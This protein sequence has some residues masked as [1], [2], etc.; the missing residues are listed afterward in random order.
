MH[1]IDN[2]VS[3][4]H[5]LNPLAQRVDNGLIYDR[6]TTYELGLE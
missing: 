3:R 1:L 5:E 6:C 2:H 4:I